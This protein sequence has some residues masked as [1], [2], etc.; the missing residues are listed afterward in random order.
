[1]TYEVAERGGVVEVAG[2][3][4]D[5]VRRALDLL[6]AHRQRARASATAVERVLVSAAVE[7][8][9]ALA[10]PAALLQARRLA[11]HRARLVAA[12]A[13]SHADL[14][15]LHDS[16]RESSTRTWLTRRRE[17]RVLFTVKFDGR[18]LVPAFQLDQHGQPRVELTPLLRVLLD[19]GI[20]G[21]T[22]WTWLTSPAALLSGEVPERVA[23]SNP[24]RALTAARRFADRPAA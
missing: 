13:Y 11:A 23:T 6:D 8:S 24:Q 22:L 20:D 14:A 4:G 5:E 19:T 21:W 12:G 7:E 1:M 2:A 17:Q 15:A 3:S 9:I 10:P 16:A 18:T